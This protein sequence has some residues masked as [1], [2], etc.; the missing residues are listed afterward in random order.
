MK[1]HNWDELPFL[2]L[3]PKPSIEPRFLGWLLSGLLA[4]V[5]LGL[6]ASEFLSPSERFWPI[7]SSGISY[8]ALAVIICPKSQSPLWVKLLASAVAGIF[9]L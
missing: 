7:L 1:P 6:V 9:V 4:S 5:G 3:K 2:K 8:V